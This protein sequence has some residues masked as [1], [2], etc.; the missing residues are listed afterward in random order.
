MDADD[1]LDALV[2]RV[3][4]GWSRHVIDGCAWG[5]SRVERAGGATTLEGEELGGTRRLSANVWR[6]AS[7]TRL[8]PCE[9]P[10]EQVLEVLRALPERD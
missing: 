7:G 1:D 5:I 3:P 2:E 6:I 10:A 8:R 4:I 9:M